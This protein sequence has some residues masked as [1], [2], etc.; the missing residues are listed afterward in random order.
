VTIAACYVSPEGVVLGA[1]STVSA[2]IAP[3]GFHYLN[4][5]QKVFE[6]GNESTLGAV[7]WGLGA[8]GNTSH[9]TQ[10][11]ILADGFATAPPTDILDIATKFAAQVQPLY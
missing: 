9:R 10:I 3:H 6:V 4:H 1:D 5:A 2:Y 11:A 7:V 8:L